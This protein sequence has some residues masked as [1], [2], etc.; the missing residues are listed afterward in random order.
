VIEDDGSVHLGA[1]VIEDSSS[2]NYILERLRSEEDDDSELHLRCL[3][4]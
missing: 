1:E 3:S 4:D 2:G